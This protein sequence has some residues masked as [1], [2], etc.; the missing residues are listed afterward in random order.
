[1]AKRSLEIWGLLGAETRISRELVLRLT[2]LHDA[3]PAGQPHSAGKA[4][5]KTHH[6]L[7]CFSRGV[8]LC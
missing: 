7:R 8:V 4:N 2:S 5:D 6:T 3:E 1:M